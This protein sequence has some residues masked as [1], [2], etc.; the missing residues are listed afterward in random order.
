MLG[1][2]RTYGAAFVTGVL[3]A[4][5][6][7]PLYWLPLGVLGVCGFVLLWDAA[8]SPKAALL[9]GWA[10][11]LGH[12]AVGSYWIL[13]AFYVPP[14][15]YALLGPPM[16]L[17]LAAILGF[18]PGLAAGTSRWLAQRA[19]FLFNRG[20]RLFLL[21]I[22]WT[23]AEWLRGHIFTGYPWNPLGHVWAFSTALLQSASLFGIYGLG[24]F[25]FLVLAAP[26]AGWR[27][28]VAGVALVGVAGLGGHAV[29]S[30][31]L[32][33]QEARGAP[34]VRI[35]QPNIAQH[36]K[37]RPQDQVQHI[38]E[39]LELSHRPGF[40]NLAAVVWPETAVPFIVD[41]LSPALPILATAAPPGGYLLTGVARGTE[42]ARDGVWNSLIAI[43]GSGAIRAHYDKSHL[44][45]FGEYI[46]FH[47]Q[48]API[49]GTV[50][51]RG[52]FEE[53]DGPVTL[54]LPGLPPFSP[55]ICYEAIFP[56]E[57]GDALS[58]A[59]RPGWLLNV[60][61]DAWFGMTPGPYQH[62]AQA[63][64]RAIEL[65]LPLVRV[66]N[67]GISAIV[68]GFG[69]EVA[70]TPLGSEGV[71][72]GGL[73]E[74]LPPTW[75]SRF[76]SATAAALGLTLLLLTFLGRKRGSAPAIAF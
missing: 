27:A 12:F 46:P 8:S 26:V 70:A 43:D 14:G 64:L 53:G 11:G 4:L 63:R 28:I 41:P 65:G 16:V 21:A 15:D 62:Y 59:D 23:A 32:E 10:W 9:R 6:M 3:A 76:G 71:L 30:S 17:G 37:W 44:V 24:A 47:R 73:P 57:I 60:T 74:A 7:P 51:G 5:A 72:D 45:P 56:V 55:M 13:E 49:S 48:L 1:G 36:E 50:G 19:P 40:S 35:V 68:D 58:R 39:L 2:W 42:Q 31:A 67:S 52:S 20:R 75:Q 66:A 34:V 61:D 22:A 29:L 54:S 69:R 18:F 33:S 38:N 25:T